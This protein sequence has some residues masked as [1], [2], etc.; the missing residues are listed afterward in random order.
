M[1]NLDVLC[2]G[3]SSFDL[4]FAVPAHP[5]SDE[6]M[7]AEALWACGGG[8]AA[9]AAVVV[10]RLEGT[11]AYAGYLG[12]DVFG[13]RHLAELKADQVNTDFIIRGSQATPLS[14]VLAKPNGERALINYRAAAPLPANSI[15]FTSVRAKVMLFDGHEPELSLMALQQ[16]KTHGSQTVLDAG[17]VHRGTL[18]LADQVDYLVCSEKF[19]LDF[20]GA[21]SV[22]SALP[23]LVENN[24]NVVITLGAQGLLWQTAVDQGHLSAYPVNAIDTT[25]AGDAFHGAFALCLAQNKAWPETLKFSSAVAA[26]T[27]TKMGARSGLP[28]RTAVVKFLAENLSI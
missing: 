18:A 20:T 8:P 6:K 13:D 16:A 24:P 25:G 28:N 1:I 14:A 15:D 4:T 26:L 12:A 23:K 17:S 21:A 7:V 5:T 22:E 10:T 3:A 9:N 19:A 27:C 11:A 2:V